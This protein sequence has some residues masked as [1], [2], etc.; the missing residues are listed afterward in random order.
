MANSEIL[1]LA[2]LG[3]CVKDFTDAEIGLNSIGSCIDSLVSSETSSECIQVAQAMLSKLLSL[4]A[5][6]RNMIED[7]NDYLESAGGNENE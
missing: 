4:E 7:A 5:S 2:F 3:A 6:I 1:N